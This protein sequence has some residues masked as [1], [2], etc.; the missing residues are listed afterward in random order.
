MTIFNSTIKQFLMSYSNRTMIRFL[1]LLSTIFLVPSLSASDWLQFRGPNGSSRNADS[2]CPP[3]IDAEQTIAWKKDLPGKGPSGPIVVGDRVYLTCSGGDK[4]DQL[5]TI[6]FDKNS[7]EKVWQRR[8]W[9][10]GR[11]FCHPLSANAAPT[12]TSDGEHIYVFFSSNDLAC[13][14][15][16]GN[17]KWFRGLAY[18]HPRAGHDTGM[19]SSPVLCNNLVIVQVEN[20]GDSFAAGINKQTGET[21]WEV[22]RDAEASWSSPL[23]IK[24]DGD[25][26]DVVLMV[27]QARV[28]C[29][30]AASGE[31]IWEKEGPCNPIVSPILANQLILLPIN[32]TTAYQ[33]GS[34]G[35]LNEIWNSPQMRPTNASYVCDDTTIYTLDRT[36][37]VTASELQTGKRGWKARVGGSYWSTPVLAGGYLFFFNQDG[38][39]N[40]V[41][42][43]DEGKVVSTC[44]FEGSFLASPA[45]SDD[46][47]FIRTDEQLMKIAEKP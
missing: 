27:S 35:S 44:K 25:R 40:V 31:T 29:L 21:I 14:D 11:C 46:A 8:L 20:Q 2:N 26:P 9:A 22:K 33:I 4:Q 28:S 30:N 17:L 18:D 41:D 47:I 24:S 3:V 38:E 15:L 1:F 12:P 10:T 37:V 42:T 32:G 19:S 43:K 23:V 7:G 5:Y 45:I 34:D 16:D 39:A 36:G 6:C 13:Y